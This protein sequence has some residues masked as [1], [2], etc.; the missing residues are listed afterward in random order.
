MPQGDVDIDYD[1]IFGYD[2]FSVKTP[3]RAVITEQPVV[4]NIIDVTLVG[5]V[6]G[7][8]RLAVKAA[9]VMLEDAYAS[10]DTTARFRTRRLPRRRQAR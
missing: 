8:P 7:G 9:R 4:K 1:K 10:R 5:L 2:E 6:G 3:R